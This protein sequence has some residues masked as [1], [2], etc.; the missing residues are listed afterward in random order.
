MNKRMKKISIL[1]ILAAIIVLPL[2]AQQKTNLSSAVD[3]ASYAIGILTGT[4]LRESLEQFPGGKV[5]L[6]VIAEAFVQTLTGD[7]E[8]FL[9]N[10]EEA[11]NYIQGFVME[12]TIKEAEAAKEEESRFLAEN[13]TKAGV[14]T[15]ESGLQYKVLKQGEGGKPSLDDNV[16][17]HYTGSLLNG[18]VFDSSVERGEPIST[19][20][21]LVIQGWTEVLQLMQVGSIFIVW[22][23]SELGYGTQGNGPIKPN[24]VLVFEMELLGIEVV[25]SE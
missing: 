12:A 11:Q 4:G 8:A 17:V 2:A 9:I 7:A 5:N 14:I 15:T 20:V 10:R 21:T 18:Y 22:I 13:K 23:P 19:S 24:S 25:E 3:S 1:F 16:T 6:N